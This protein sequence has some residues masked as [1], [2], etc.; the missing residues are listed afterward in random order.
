MRLRSDG[1]VEGL[2]AGQ[3]VLLLDGEQQLEAE[4]GALDG[5]AADELEEDGDRG[6]VVGAEDRVVRVLPAAVDEHG[7]D[8]AGHGD[9]VE[10]R[11]EQQ[12]LVGR[13][14]GRA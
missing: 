3:R 13:G 4:R 1:R 2:G 10:V 14:R 9:R 6:L 8:R 12:V 11:A 5:R 7:L